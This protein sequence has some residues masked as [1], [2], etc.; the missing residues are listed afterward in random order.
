MFLVS[1]SLE[2][3]EK[4]IRSW[5]SKYPSIALLVAAVYFEWII[6]RAIIGLS[7]RPNRQV[8]D[9][10]ISVYGLKAYKDQW[11]TDTSH[12]ENFLTLPQL[13][14]DWHG[15]T[16]AFDARNLLVHGKDRY[17]RNMATPKVDLLLNG[18]HDIYA[19]CLKHG[20]DINKRL[21]VR[22]KAIRC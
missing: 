11:K 3:R 5:L 14:R 6:C 19:Y 4:T 1:D 15:V 2:W 22:K 21:P 9:D 10:L 17:T 13:I 16:K 20:L 18:V 7:R 8:R 12:L